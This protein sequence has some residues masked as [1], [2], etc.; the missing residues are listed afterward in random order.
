M[1]PRSPGFVRTARAANNGGVQE[2]DE[3]ARE[4]ATIL[5][6]ANVLADPGLT[7]SYETD[8]TRRFHGRARLVVRP[9]NTEET[10][11]IVRVCATAGA[12]I[13]P[14]G[15]NTGLVGGSVPRGG[16]VVLSMVRLRDLEPVDRLAAQ[17]TAGAGVTIAEL[18]DHAREAGLE[19][20]VDL[21]SRGTATV[22]GTIATNAGGMRVARYGPTRAQVV[23]LEAVLADGQVVSRLSGL[24]KDNTGYDLPGLITGSEGTLAIVTRARLRLVPR[25]DARATALLGMIGTGA[26]VEL[27]ATLRERM[28]SLDAAEAFFEEGMDLVCAH[29]GA[30]RPFAN[31]QACYLLLECAARS[32]PADELAAALAGGAGIVES[33]FARDPAR[34]RALWRYREAHTESINAAGVPHK[35]DVTLPSAQLARFEGEV[36]QRL[37]AAVPEAK[38][39]LF[40]HVGDGNLHVNVLGVDPDDERADDA[41]LRFV[42]ELG[43]SIS[44]EHGIGVAKVPWLHLTRSSADITAMR[45]IKDALDPQ[46][47]LNPGVIFPA[48]PIRAGG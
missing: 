25:Q 45:R 5:G 28:P 22:G 14:Q 17:V 24:T 12:V 10:A 20:P 41:I 36:R 6:A 48:V 4:L 26:A 30:A 31:R 23:G 13:V 11:A 2:H 16:E 43:G 32:D 46:G 33:A 47:I 21:A 9:A 34:R 8:W 38:P 7:A 37:A 18:Q 35:L 27:V 15:G 29:T 3:L 1:P 44:A 39:V 42:A 40:G 19:Y